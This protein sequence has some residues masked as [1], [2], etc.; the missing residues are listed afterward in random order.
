MQ[1]KR[2]LPPGTTFRTFRNSDPPKLVEIW[3]RSHLGR[4]SVSPLTIAEF[5]S[6][7][8]AKLYFDPRGLILACQDGDPVGFIHAGFGADKNEERLAETWGVISAVMIVPEWQRNGLG[9]A[10]LGQAEEYL[11]QQG[12][13]VIYAGGMRP[14]NPFYLGLYGGSELPGFLDSNEAARPF[15]ENNGYSEVDRCLVFHKDLLDMK[16]LV[17]RRFTFLRRKMRVHYVSDTGHDSWWWTS[18]MGPFDRWKLEVRLIDTSEAVAELSC[19]DMICFSRIWKQRT[20][21]IMDIQVAESWQGKGV[22]KF[23]LQELLVRLWDE[24]IQRVEVQTMLKNH[25]AIGLYKA[26]GFKQVDQGMIYRQESSW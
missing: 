18:L 11:S 4:G 14:V 15:F 16:A 7:V 23:L 24:G 21:G 13:E 2:S 5:D 20:V 1:N 6:L 12:S 8:L 25:R 19:W 10:L 3:N 9:R 17:D 22:G 26:S